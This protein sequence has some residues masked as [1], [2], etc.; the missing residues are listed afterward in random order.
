MLCLQRKIYTGGRLQK[1]LLYPICETKVETIWHVLW[2]CRESMGVWQE[3]N[4]KIHKLSL[5]ESDG[6]R[7][8]HQLMAKLDHPSL[9]E[10]F[11]VARLVW[12]QRNDFVFGRGF[13]NPVQLVVQARE[14]L[15]LFFLKC[16]IFQW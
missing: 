7:L 12:H 2:E 6:L 13:T 16:R 8:V 3:C 14:A 15:V 1:T 10:A 9:M 11:F 4:K 5:I